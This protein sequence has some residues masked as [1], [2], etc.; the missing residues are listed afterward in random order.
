MSD[1][2]AAQRGGAGIRAFIAIDLDAAARSEAADLVAR[3]RRPDDGVRWVRA[4]ALHVTLRFLGDIEPGQVSALTRSVA[5]E[6][7]A[8]TPFQM[9]LGAVHLFP[10]PRRP[11]VVALDLEPVESLSELAAAVERG[12][13]AQG[14][15]PEARSFRAHLTLGRLKRG[16]A[17]ATRGLR[18][19]GVTSAVEEVVLFRSELGRDGAK[20]TALAHMLLGGGS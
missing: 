10:S 20:Y 5:D 15:E 11:R 19:A 3:L 1:V 6:V 8:L 16:R 18:A 7:A 2:D 12:T 9:Q 14:F 17:P 4:E 13:R